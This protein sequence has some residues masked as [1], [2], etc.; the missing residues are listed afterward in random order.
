MRRRERGVGSGEWGVGK[1]QILRLYKKL[2]SH[3]SE[4]NEKRPNLGEFR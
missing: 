1:M 4:Q 2:S 3:F